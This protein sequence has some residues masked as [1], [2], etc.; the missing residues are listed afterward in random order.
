MRIN[1]VS[2]EKALPDLAAIVRGGPDGIMLPKPETGA[3]VTLLDN[4]LTAL[5]QRDGIAPGRIKIIPVATETARAVLVLRQLSRLQ[6][7]P[8]RP[9]L[10]RRGS[11]GGAG[12]S[13]TKLL[14]GSYDFTYR[15]A[16]SLCLIGAKAAGVTPIDT[17]WGDFRDAK[18]LREDSEA[19][20]RAGFTGKIAI[21]PDQV[22][23]INEAFSPSASDVEHAQR[24]VAAFDAAGH[25]HGRS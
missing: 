23:V 19:A 6:R 12:R 4:Y 18:G 5:E 22:A 24:V 7:A 8:A 1:P 20:R 3:D 15:L 14:D 16:R 21:H 2:T 13:T 11:V 10:G 9:H 25:G 17:I